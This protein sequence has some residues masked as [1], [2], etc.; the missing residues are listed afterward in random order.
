MRYVGRFFLWV[1]A[2]VG[3]LIVVV[4]T[5]LA[6]WFFTGGEDKE[7]L[8]QRIVLSLDLNEGVDEM[9]SGG[10]FKLLSR[11]EGHVLRDIIAGLEK[12]QTD[13]R[14]SGLV[15]RMGDSGIDI[16][17]AQEVREAVSRFRQAGKFAVAYAD[18]FSAMPGA[19]TE[20]YLASVFDEIAMQPSGELAI[21]GVAIEVPFVADAL[22]KI[23]V[24]ARM[25]QR[26]EYKSAVE[27]FTRNSMSAPA[28]SNLQ[29]LANSWLTQL[30]AGIAEGRSIAPEQARASIDQSPL[31]AKEALDRKLVDT[32]DYWPAVS[33]SAKARAG[34]HSGLVSFSHYL[35]DGKL[36][37]TSGPTVALIHGIGPIVSSDG[38]GTPFDDTRIFA[39]ESVAKAIAD[40]AAAPDVRAILLR[41]D[42]PGGSYLASDTVWNAV[43]HARSK[44]KP[45]IASMGGV[46]ASGGYFVA[47]AADR[48][49]ASPGTLTGS[50]GVYGGKF[51]TEGLWPKIGVNWDIVQAGKHASI[52]SPF[53]DFQPSAEA[54]LGTMMDAVYQDFTAKVAKGRNL[55]AAQVETVAGG[56]VW[57][58]EAASKVGLVDALGGLKTAIDAAKEAAGIDPKQDI[59]LQEFPLPKTPFE[60]LM[61]LM[62]EEG[63]AAA[64][65]IAGSLGLRAQFSKVLEARFGPLLDEIDALRPPAGNLQMPPLRVRY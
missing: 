1:F 44:G 52:W 6:T 9:P 15:V 10:P 16:A 61:S 37:Y 32:L 23:G 34:A 18:S 31:L 12:A 19:T 55:S 24:A 13:N 4:G 7:P 58:G 30:T 63:G 49:V 53:R 42:S 5:S 22:G 3:F 38:G 65:S 62:T 39:A 20:Y 11:D 27:T 26:K 60:Q 45:V 14:V 33:D 64:A 43:M 36:P 47:M 8:P 2:V 21:T 35:D 46:A 25:E 29:D 57:S 59:T 41:I 40:A 51:V 50:I 28:R 48:I 54:R 17:T 56:R